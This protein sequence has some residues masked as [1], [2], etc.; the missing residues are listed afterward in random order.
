MTKISLTVLSLGSLLASAASCTPDLGA[1]KAGQANSTGGATTSSAL[2]GSSNSGELGGS[3]SSTDCGTSCSVA[4]RTN[5]IATGGATTALVTGGRAGAAGAASVGVGGTSLGGTGGKAAGAGSGTA[6]ASGGST[7]TT[8]G[9]AGAAACEIPKLSPFDPPILKYDFDAGSGDEVTDSSGNGYNG[10]VL[11]APAWSTT[12]RFGGAM[13]FN[14]ANQYVQLPQ[15]VLSSAEAVT[16]AAW[17]KLSAN[18]ALSALFD[19]GSSATNHFY[20]RTNGGTTSGSGMTFGAQV[21]GGPVQEIA[22]AYTLPNG[23]W[24]HVALVIG[25]GTASLYIDGLSV[26]SRSMTF[27]PSALGSTAGN[28]IG[29]TQGS[30]VNLYGSVD[31]F[32][33]YAQALSREEVQSIA[34]AGT[35][36]VHFRFDEPCGTKAYEAWNGA[37]VAEL[38]AGGTWTS[39]R[40]GGALSLDGVNQFVQLPADLVRLCNDLT[41]AMWVQRRAP[42][43][44]ERLF[45]FGQGVSSSM[46]LA[47]W[48]SFNVMQFAAKLNGASS[49][50]SSDELQ[51]ASA[52]TA[53][54]PQSGLW[55]HVAVVLQSGKGHLYLNG[56]EVGNG[57]IGI[58]PSDI[59]STLING[60]GQP[61]YMDEPYLA[62]LVDDLRISCRAFSV[63]EIKI[64]AL[65]GQ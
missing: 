37:S 61:L 38:P 15:N 21:N 55:S 41:V 1:L 42:K 56:L 7:A 8:T 46:T 32:R 47:A 43:N 13:T 24:K 17:V 22:T 19:I 51:M 3:S 28:W 60:V 58:K 25:D 29:H 34:P 49:R 2:G 4:G 36:Y 11:G 54:S 44:W 6:D 64:L 52:S 65:V 33:I 14:A 45:S 20:L 63:S 27:A 35:D 9:A 40:I 48:T 5:A 18:P 59:G 12:G 53:L 62:G 16:V 50:G 30:N 39:G 31:D 23:V 57:T 10:T 26:I